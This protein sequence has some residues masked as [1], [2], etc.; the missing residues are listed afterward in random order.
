[1]DLLKFYVCLGIKR[2]FSLNKIMNSI[3][4]CCIF[5]SEIMPTKKTPLIYPIL[6]Q[7]LLWM[8]IWEYVIIGV[9]ISAMLCRISEG[10]LIFH[11]IN[12][13]NVERRNLLW[14]ILDSRWQLET[15][16]QQPFGTSPDYCL[17]DN[18]CI[19]WR[20]CIN[21]GSSNTYLSHPF[22]LTCCEPVKNF[23]DD[24]S[25]KEDKEIL[26]LIKD[27]QINI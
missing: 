19:L 25:D 22:D 26:T 6:S 2:F 16:Y 4:F 27:K 10:Y 21:L 9:S 17:T 20:K 13:R 12:T 8:S 3:W 23:W 18:S 7:N 24:E 5:I 1:M 14:Q 15:D 11:W